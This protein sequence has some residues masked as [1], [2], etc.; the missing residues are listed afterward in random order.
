MGFPQ[1]AYTLT[2]NKAQWQYIR[3]SLSPSG[4]GGDG[5]GRLPRGYE[6]RK[7]KLF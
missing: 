6:M 2:K 4:H 5:Q 1:E 7:G 3:G